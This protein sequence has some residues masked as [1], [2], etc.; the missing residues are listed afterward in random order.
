M[1]KDLTT[2]QVAER[3]GSAERTVRL[4][5]KQGKFPNAYRQTTPFGS[6]WLIPETD[7]RTFEKP[8]QGRPPKPVTEKAP[9]KRAKKGGK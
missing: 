9:R 1:S 6:Y 4:W 7:L 3:T 5:C 8:T 2:E